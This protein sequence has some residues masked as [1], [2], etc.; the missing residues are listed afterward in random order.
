MRKTG[1]TGRVLTTVM[2]VASIGTASI[3]TALAGT[4]GKIAGR[5]TDKSTGEPLMG[6]NVMVEGTALGSVTDAEGGYSVLQVPPGTFNI[7]LSLLGYAKTN[8]TGIRVFIDQ[9]AAVDAALSA[10]TIV[11]QAVSIVAERKAVKKDVATSVAAVSSQELA[12]LPFNSVSEVVGLQA[13]VEEGLVIRGGGAGQAL[14]MLDGVT[15]RDPRNNQPIS[16][17]SLSAIQEI[18][19]ERGGFNA[20]YGQVRSGIVNVVTKEGDKNKYSGSVTL[21]A[22]PPAKKYFG[23]EPGDANL[24]GSP[25]DPNSTMLR[26]YLDP[27]V[28]WTGTQ[29]GGWDLYTQRQYPQFEGWNSISRTL[30]TDGN[31]ANDLSPAAAQELFR[32]QHRRQEINTRMHPASLNPDKARLTVS[33][34]RPRKLPRSRRVMRRLNRVSE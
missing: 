29:N 6:V 8:V 16:G 25:F 17:V 11:G 19:V 7:T 10:E 33:C 23:A 34:V 13:G 21:K 27:A 26:P 2:L 20:E 32:W 22:A 18:S 1:W 24:T 30:M 9:T 28:C 15:L 12:T 14:F 3:G 4:T 5:V 31:P